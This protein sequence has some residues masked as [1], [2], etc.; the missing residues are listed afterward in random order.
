M[1]SLIYSD[2]G[3]LDV[4]NTYEKMSEDTR[5]EE[6]FLTVSLLITSFS[7]EGTLEQRMKDLIDL[8]R[9]HLHRIERYEEAGWAITSRF[10]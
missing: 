4:V 9:T 10:D 8:Q 7:F 2:D 5:E 1:S 3:R 6:A